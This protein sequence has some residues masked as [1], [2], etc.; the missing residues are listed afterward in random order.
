MTEGKQFTIFRQSDGIRIE[1]EQG[2]LTTDPTP[3]QYEGLHRMLD[4]GVADGFEFTLLCNLPGFTLLH[5]WF[6]KDYPLPLH[7]HNRDC[8]YHVVSGSA[9]LG[10]EDIG[11]GDSFFIPAGTPYTYRAGPEGVEVLEFRHE[12]GVDF[13]NYAKSQAFYDKAVATVLANRDGWRTAT[14]PQRTV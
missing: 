14:R 6:K 2:V 8:L 5:A 4:V 11:P 1:G 9:R 3:V 12:M 7:S 13:Q 10:T